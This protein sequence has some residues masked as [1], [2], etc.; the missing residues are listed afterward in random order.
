MIKKTG[1]VSLA[2]VV[3]TGCAGIVIP[4][5]R[6]AANEASVRGAEEL[7]ALGVPAARMHLELAKDETATAKRLASN[8]DSRALTVLACA[9]SDAE[10]ALGLAREASVHAGALKAAEDLQAVQARGNRP[11]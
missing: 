9:Q 11:L 2:V 6:L 10:L 1:F 5:D 4:P 8:G 3:F 7:G